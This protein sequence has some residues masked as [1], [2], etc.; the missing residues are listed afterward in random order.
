MR[1]RSNE[2]LKFGVAGAGAVKL[3]CY[4]SPDQ[5]SPDRF[6]SGYQAS[7]SSGTVTDPV[8]ALF[9]ASLTRR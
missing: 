9:T 6:W 8:A 7:S 1:I 3:P 5:T 2:K 4:G